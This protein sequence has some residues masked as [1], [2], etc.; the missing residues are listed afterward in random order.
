MESRKKIE[1]NGNYYICVAT[2]DEI[3][4]GRSKQVRFGEEYESQ[5][6]IIRYNNKLYCLSNICPHRHLDSI[7]RGII[8]DGKVTCPE[9]GW[10]YELSSGLNVEPHKGIKNLKVYEVIEFDGF[11]YL[12]EIQFESPKWKF[13]EP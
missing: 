9:H 6:A 11:I 5:V 13:Y 4:E 12:P 1:V 10:T 7:H 2:S 3:K 8:A